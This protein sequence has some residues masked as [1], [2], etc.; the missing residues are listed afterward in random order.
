MDTLAEGTGVEGMDDALV[1]EGGFEVY[2]VGGTEVVDE[3][4]LDLEA[5]DVSLVE[6]AYGGGDDDFVEGYLLEVAG[7]GGAFEL[8]P[9]V[10]H[11]G[12]PPGVV[13]LVQSAAS[14]AALIP[15]SGWRARS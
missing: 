3:M 15:A 11:W 12:F 14:Q 13:G 7:E 6:H 2:E 9:V 5:L 4:V 10:G 1:E 8:L